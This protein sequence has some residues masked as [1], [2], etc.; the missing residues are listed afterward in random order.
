MAKCKLT[1]EIPAKLFPTS[2]DSKE[3]FVK[4]KNLDFSYNELTGE[5]R[6]EITSCA[7]LVRL[8]VSHN[9][10]S[11]NPTGYFTYENFPRLVQIEL[12][13]NNFSGGIGT[14]FTNPERVLSRV[15]I[16]NNNFSG[17]ILPKPSESVYLSLI[18]I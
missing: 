15:D 5:L 10:M 3:G 8:W 17:P 14:L 18:H 11:G 12:N 7:N 1:G 2:K 9:K 6:K 13:D 4:L 16:S